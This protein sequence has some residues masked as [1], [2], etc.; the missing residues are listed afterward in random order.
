MRFPIFRPDDLLSEWS[1][2]F[3]EICCGCGRSSHA[4]VKLLVGELGDLTFK[5]YLSRLVCKQCKARPGPVYLCTGH[6]RRMY[7]GGPPDWALQVVRDPK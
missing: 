7:G 2:C 4:P 6:D 3:L 5:A 1:D